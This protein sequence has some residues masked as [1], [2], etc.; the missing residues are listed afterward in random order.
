MDIFATLQDAFYIVSIS[1]M[2]F[3][4]L[5]ILGSLVGALV[6]K[7][8]IKRMVD[9]TMRLPRK[10]MAFVESFFKGLSRSR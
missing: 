9:N 1:F 5:V 4:T 10:G 8:K 6:L 2:G 3:L 7:S